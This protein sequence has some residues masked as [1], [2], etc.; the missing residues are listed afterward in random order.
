S[1]EL[2]ARMQLSVPESTDIEG[3]SEATRRIYGLDEK[4]AQPLGRQCLLARRLLERG[5]RFVQVYHGG[6]SADW[7]AH[8]SIR[9]N[10]TTRAKEYDQPV[11][12][13]VKDLDG[14]GLLKDTLVMGVT[15]FGR[16]PVSQ[17]TGNTAGR[18][19]HP[20]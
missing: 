5:V 7:D 19:H 1:Y 8:G 18:D 4:E 2:A 13:L 11:A 3:E 9:T 12:A 20:D 15:E 6:S 17:G 14:R 10:H 16:T